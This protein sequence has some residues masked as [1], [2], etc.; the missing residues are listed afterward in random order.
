MR[1][2]KAMAQEIFQTNWLELF[3]AMRW[4]GWVILV[5][6]AGVITLLWAKKDFTKGLGDVALFIAL[7]VIA[8]VG[9]LLLGV[10]FV[11]VA[12]FLLPV[13]LGCGI[14]GVVGI[15]LSEKQ[16]GETCPYCNGRIITE[17]YYDPKNKQ[18]GKR[19]ICKS[20]KHTWHDSLANVA[21]NV[22]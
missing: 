4:W 22:S 21:R 15:L 19:V 13:V 8:L 1:K 12:P 7:I 6:A 17:I 11:N 2:E 14:G 5:A 16:K 10:S 9:S 3:F 20:C 18:Q